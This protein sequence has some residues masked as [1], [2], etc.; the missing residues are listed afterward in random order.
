MTDAI[1]TVEEL[2]AVIGIAPPPVK[3][4]IIDHMDETAAD[5]I[6]ASTLV[7][8][9]I[10]KADGPR[11]TLAGAPAGF[12]RAADANTLVLPL[13]A[14]DDPHLPEPGDGAGVLCL[15]PGVGETLRANGRVKSR[16]NATV[17]ITIEECFIHCAKAL[18]RSDFWEGPPSSAPN[19]SSAFVNQTRFLALATMD[20]RGLIDISPKGDPAGLLIQMDGATAMLAERPGNRL[21]FGYRNMID[22]PRIAAFAIIPGQASAAVLQGHA[23]LTASEDMRRRFTVDEKTPKLVSVIKDATAAVRPSPALAH[24]AVW[25]GAIA[26]P[27]IDPATAMVAHVKLNKTAGLAA[28]MMRL[29]INRGLLVSGLKANYKNELY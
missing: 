17:E 9:G 23:N 24:S 26:P 10:G 8:V 27:T 20:H 19:E 29:A 25:R 15:V 21:A 16:N 11:V 7:F 14:L 1:T 28:T 6:A 13:E 5:W 12:A 18:I 4:K 3:M 2:E 22:Q